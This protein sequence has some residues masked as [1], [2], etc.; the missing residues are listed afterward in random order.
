MRLAKKRRDPQQLLLTHVHLPCAYQHR[1]ENDPVT[2]PG[3]NPGSLCEVL[4]NS[5]EQL[6]NIHVLP[7]IFRII[8]LDDLR[9]S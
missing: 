1:A 8:L 5:L 2:F 7:N 9:Q 6:E 4:F 3:T